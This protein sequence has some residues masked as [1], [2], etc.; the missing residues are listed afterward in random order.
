MGQGNTADRIGGLIAVLIGLLALGEAF[1]LYP[2]RVGPL[3]GDH[4][5]FALLGSLMLFGGLLLSFVSRISAPKTEFPKPAALLVMT[6]VLGLLFAYRFLL[7]VTGYAL[8]TFFV[9]MLLFKLIGAYRWRNSIL[10]A[11]LLTTA[12][13][14]VFM[15]W[16]QMS[17]PSGVLF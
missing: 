14:A 15:A 8:G 6:G 9:S 10:Y 1:R 17:F 7:P 13:Y 12:L 3:V 4:M 2:Q 11:A 5:V 16:L